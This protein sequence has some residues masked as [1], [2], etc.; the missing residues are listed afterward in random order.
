MGFWK[1]VRF[2]LGGGNP[3]AYENEYV[4]AACFDDRG[5]QD[6]VDCEACVT[7]CTFCGAES[8]VPIAASL[9]VVLL[10]VHECLSREYDIAGNNLTYDGES[11]SYLG[12]VWT[13]TDLLQ[14]HLGESLPN[15]E[16]GALMKALCDG[17]GEHVWCR[18]HPYSL[19][20]D[21]KFC[22]SWKKFCELTMYHKRYFFLSETESQELFT[23][24]ALL[25]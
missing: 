20:T 24:L 15:D 12:Q 17:L 19:M 23:P 10:Y 2:Q 14:L 22:W 25:K 6:F 18:Q 13:T 9:I 16:Q 21:E 5:L 4:C 11:G 8:N 7:D 3:E 1:D